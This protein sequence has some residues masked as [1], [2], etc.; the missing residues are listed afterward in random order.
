MHLE[1]LQIAFACSEHDRLDGRQEHV[2]VATT[3][4]HP[5]GGGEVDGVAGTMSQSVDE[6]ERSEEEALLARLEEANR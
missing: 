5:A 4:D 1:L 6:G 2:V 3:R